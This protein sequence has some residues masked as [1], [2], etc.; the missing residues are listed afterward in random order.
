MPK[1]VPERSSLVSEV[2][3]VLYAH[4]GAGEG[5]KGEVIMWA[6]NSEVGLWAASVRDQLNTRI[7]LAFHTQSF[8]CITDVQPGVYSDDMLQNFTAL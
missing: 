5:G 6:N 2:N 7:M 1:L 4:T 8:S 3:L